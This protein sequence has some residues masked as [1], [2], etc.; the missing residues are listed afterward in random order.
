MT[1]SRILILGGPRVGKTSLAE[2][3]FVEL[4]HP[5]RHTDDLIDAHKWSEASDEVVAWIDDPGPWI[6]EGLAAVRGLRK[7][8]V[9][10]PD[11]APADRIYL[12][13]TPKVDVTPK[14]RATLRGCMTV[15]SSISLDLARRGVPITSF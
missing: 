8:L 5:V 11:G 3:L 12:S 4:G 7:W 1:D 15:W 2:R 10:H 14:H 9:A 13:D 6:I